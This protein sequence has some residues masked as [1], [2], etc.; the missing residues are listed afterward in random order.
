M[1]KT[2]N[3]SKEERTKE[4]DATNKYWRVQVELYTHIIVSTT[5]IINLILFHLN[6][7]ESAI[8]LVLVNKTT[9]YI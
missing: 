9:F 8:K 1:P 3:K 2:T 4:K 5:N 6:L 7:I